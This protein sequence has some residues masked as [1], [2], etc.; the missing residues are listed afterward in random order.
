MKLPMKAIITILANPLVMKPIGYLLERI[1]GKKP[2]DKVTAP[3]AS[4]ATL[5]AL[6]GVLSVLEPDLALIVKE[7]LTPELVGGAAAAV[8]AIVGYFVERDEG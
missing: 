1:F 6:L 2:S 7:S 5:S 8:A 3:A 4:L